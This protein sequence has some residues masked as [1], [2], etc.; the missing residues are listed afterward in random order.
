MILMITM[1]MEPHTK[2]LTNPNN[3]GIIT[4]TTEEK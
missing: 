3:L 4:S 2:H 1:A